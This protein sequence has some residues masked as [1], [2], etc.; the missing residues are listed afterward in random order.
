VQAAV[1]AV[2]SIKYFNNASSV[3]AP[4]VYHEEKKVHIFHTVHTINI[5]GYLA[6]AAGR[7]MLVFPGR[8]GGGCIKEQD[9]VLQDLG[10]TCIKNVKK[11][12]HMK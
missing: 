11:Q 8:T 12:I 7:A 9:R 1:V 5:S 4:P 10:P 2:T 6:S 3:A